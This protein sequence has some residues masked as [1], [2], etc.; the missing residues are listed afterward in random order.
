MTVMDLYPSPIKQTPVIQTNL[1]HSQTATATLRRTLEVSPS[2]ICLIQEPWIR[3]DRICG[4]NN[5]GGKIILNTNVIKPRTCIFI[6]LNLHAVALTEFCSRDLT[7]ITL[8]L[9]NQYTENPK[10]IVL[11]SAYMPS[12]EDCPPKELADLIHH[13][14]NQGLQLIVGCDSN[15]HHPLWGCADSNQRGEVLSTYLFSTQLYIAN[16]GS[17]PTWVTSRAQTIIDLTL[18]SEGALEMLTDWHVSSELSCSDHKRIRF[19]LNTEITIQPPKRNPKH[20]DIALYVE[21]LNN[22]LTNIELLTMTT[23]TENIENNVI[24]ITNS[25]I[26]SYHHS[27]PVKHTTATTTCFSKR[28]WWNAS[29]EKTKRKLRQ[30]FNRA[31]N[32]RKDEDWNRFQILRKKFKK[33]IRT[34]KRSA[35]RR[36][37]ENI[38]KQHETSRIRKLLA[39]D[40]T[41]SLNR[42][43]KTDGSYTTTD[44]ETCQILL[45]TH[46]P[47]CKIIGDSITT[48]D[49]TTNRS[50]TEQDWHIAQS[51]ITED[52]IAWAINTF[53]S[54]KAA[55][56]DEIFPGLLKWGKDCL[57]SILNKIFQACIAHNYIPKYWREVKVIFIPKPGKSDYTEAKAFRPISLTSFLLKTLERIC[58]RFLREGPLQT[59]PLHPNQ[60][61]YTTGKSTETALHNVVSK[62]ETAFYNKNSTLGVFIDIEGAFDKTTFESIQLSLLTHKVNPTIIGWI[63][64]MLRSRVVKIDL[65]GITTATVIKGCPQGGVLSPLLWNI[66]ANTLIKKLNNKGFYTVGYADDINILISGSHENMLCTSMRSALKVVEDWC[67]QYKLS[68]NPNKT[69]LILFTKKR[70]LPTLSLPKLLDTTLN[71]KSEVKYLGVTLD[72]KLLWNKHL[73]YTVKKANISLWQCKRLLGK[74]WGLSPKLMR[75]LYISV[76]RPVASYGALTWWPKVNQTTAQSELNKLQRS[77]CMAITGSMNTTPTAALQAALDLPPLHLF[78]QQEAAAST[79][80]LNLAG[81]LKTDTRIKHTKIREEVILREPLME[82]PC[83]RITKTYIFDRRYKIQLNEMDK[84]YSGIKELRIYTDG[85]KTKHGTGAGA[86]S[87]ELQIKI[88]L[89]LG[90]HTT[91]FQAECVGIIEATQAIKTRDIKNH[92]IRILTDSASV[93][94]ALNSYCINSGLILQC[95]NALEQISSNNTITL[96]WIKG[97]SGSLGN[98]A[99][100]ELARAGSDAT[101]I[102]PEPILPLPI[103]QLRVWLRERTHNLHEEIWIGTQTCRQ[104]KDAL[105]KLNKKLTKNLLRLNR[106]KLRIVLG[107]LTGHC[108]LNKHMHNIHLTDSPLCRACLTEDETVT[109]VLLHC[110]GVDAIRNET[111]S[112]VSTL[113]EAFLDLSALIDFWKE[114]GWLE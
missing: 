62:I 84:E 83:D 8:Q 87:Q 68:V 92:N 43:R 93:L 23:N 77:A 27:C 112:R 44:I 47:D 80:R 102:G 48:W 94:Q 72:S 53:Q 14:E 32:T 56:I 28:S 25:I 55:G 90:R 88:S 63:D 6:P 35:W 98:D 42:L 73:E 106:R 38:E 2:T 113:P 3:S 15:A 64:N 49:L 91:I 45:E 1:Q 7:A 33:L 21:T 79:L 75:W 24:K 20:T 61:A 51:L 4:L 40:N 16:T 59:Y 99:A 29:L 96:Q 30:L 5:I 26:S 110:S 69:E 70:K 39:M 12:D 103:N 10:N 22:T 50:P 97:H 19:V 54:H 78:I 100:D 66:V 52:K 67:K 57:T 89:P 18:A 37:C 46:F 104:T 13:C 95:H 82:A 86:F 17:E 41:R 109:H 31:K 60:H 105:P 58:D 111:I 114:L 9:G 101:S 34:R 85:S 11:A 36:F 71:L 81:L 107:T 74:N 76:I 108:T 65:N